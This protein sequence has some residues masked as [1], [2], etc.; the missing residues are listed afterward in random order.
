MPA[1][2]EV[3]VSIDMVEEDAELCDLVQEEDRQA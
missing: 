2:W 1:R 3:V